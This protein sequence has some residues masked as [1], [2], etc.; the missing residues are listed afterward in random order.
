MLLGTLAKS[1][2]RGAIYTVSKKGGM[3]VDTEGKGKV[4]VGMCSPAPT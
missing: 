2:L 4:M 1:Q 3:V